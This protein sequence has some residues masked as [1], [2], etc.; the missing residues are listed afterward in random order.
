[1]LGLVVAMLAACGGTRPSHGTGEVVVTERV[2]PNYTVFVIEDADGV[3]R[4]RFER[5]GVDQLS[6]IHI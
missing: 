2:S 6:L 1:M 5:D 3:R 4:L